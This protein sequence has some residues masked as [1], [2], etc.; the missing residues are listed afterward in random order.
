MLDQLPGHLLL[1]RTHY[2]QRLGTSV[3]SHPAA[4]DVSSVPD[5][6]PLLVAADILVTDYSSV[7]FDFANTGRPMVF[8]AY[9]YDDY[10]NSER[11]VYFELQDKAPGPMV[12]TGDELIHA[13]VTVDT[14][15]GDYEQRYQEFV[16]EFGEYDTG[17]ASRQVVDHVFFGAA[18]G[19]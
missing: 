6:A 8:F 2:L 15:R 7:M 4:R 1:V 19:K 14:W 11:G 17:T 18:R 5:I 13:L 10:A 12:R 3:T 9:D 16:A